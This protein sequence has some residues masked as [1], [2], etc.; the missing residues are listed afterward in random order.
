MFKWKQL[1]YKLHLFGWVINMVYIG[2]MFQY[3]YRVYIEGQY[4]SIMNWLMLINILYP[5]F[6]EFL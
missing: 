4:S 2:Q 3:T 5:V 6:Y 1:A